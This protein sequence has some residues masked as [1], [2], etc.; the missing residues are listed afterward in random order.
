MSELSSIFTL[1]QSLANDP[2]NNLEIWLE[3]V[4]TLARRQCLQHDLTGA[5]SLVVPDE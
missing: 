2:R 5:L 4:E 3:G 1:T